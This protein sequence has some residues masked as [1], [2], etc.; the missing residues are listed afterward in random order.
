MDLGQIGKK[1]RTELKR[2]KQKSAILAVMVLVAMY[3]WAPLFRKALV[4][5]KPSGPPANSVTQTTGLA[6]TSP[7]AAPVL[8]DAAPPPPVSSVQ[9][10]HDWN[11]LANWIKD[12]QH[13]RSVALTDDFRNPF[14]KY[15]DPDSLT[16]ADAGDAERSKLEPVEPQE[17]DGAKLGLVLQATLVGRH[18]RLATINGFSYA[19][20][21]SVD[22]P[23][24]DEQE[25]APILAEVHRDHVLLKYDGQLFR[26]DIKTTKLN[27]GSRIAGQ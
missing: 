1:L 3:F 22:L 2:N 5:N 7:A 6:A 25:P 24:A 14:A 26:L 27:P 17:L 19:E 18:K 12:D 11:T 15:V 9:A 21:S 8:M 20:G 23:T 4:G 13:M 16:Q 10:K